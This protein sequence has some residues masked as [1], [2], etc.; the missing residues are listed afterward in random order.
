MRLPTMQFVD[1]TVYYRAAVQAEHGP[2]GLVCIAMTMVVLACIVRCTYLASSA[3]PSP[4]PLE[5]WWW[6]SVVQAGSGLLG[7]G[8][9]ASFAL[10]C[11]FFP[12][13]TTCH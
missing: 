13:I 7:L 5:R 2:G 11:F 10:N 9:V 1:L 8:L 3:P 6:R 4:P 12:I